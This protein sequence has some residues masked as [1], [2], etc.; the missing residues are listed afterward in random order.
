MEE[1]KKTKRTELIV[2]E[3]VVTFCFD[4]KESWPSQIVRDLVCV[5]KFPNVRYGTAVRSGEF[6]HCCVLF[7]KKWRG[8]QFFYYWYRT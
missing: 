5:Y 1:E 2:Y 7:N 6:P 4:Y 8:E 3:L